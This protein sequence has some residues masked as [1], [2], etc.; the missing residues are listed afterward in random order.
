M[1]LETLDLSVGEFEHATGW[2]LKP[3]GACHGDVCVPLGN[4]GPVA[5]RVSAAA[6]AGKL[7]MPLLHDPVV[8]LY[9]LGHATLGG[10][11]LASAVAPELELPDVN[12]KPFKLSS[13][14]GKKVVLVAWSPY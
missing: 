12:G 5:G 8:G 6:V 4:A 11:A 14:R 2:T 1:I 10:R 9:A 3:E 13:L 7:G